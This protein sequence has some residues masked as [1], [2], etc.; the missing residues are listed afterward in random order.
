MNIKRYVW[1]YLRRPST[2]FSAARLLESVPLE[3][4]LSSR[5]S[6]MTALCLLVQCIDSR[7]APLVVLLEREAN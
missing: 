5:E 7:D 6:G 1:Q 3:S 4:L 2:S